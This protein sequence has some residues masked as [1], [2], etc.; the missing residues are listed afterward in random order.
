MP[1]SYVLE[2]VH[3][4]FAETDRHFDLFLFEHQF[5]GSRQEVPNNF[6]IPD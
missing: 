3:A 1:S 4:A 2:E 5:T 6:N